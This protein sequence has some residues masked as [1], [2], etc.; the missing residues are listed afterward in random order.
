MC[1]NSSSTIGW[2][3][4]SD[5]GPPSGRVATTP[6][7]LVIDDDSIMRELVRH[8]LEDAGY[9]VAL[10]SGGAQGVDM[11]K[12]LGPALVI[13]DFAMPEV[14]GRDALRQIRAGPATASVP[15]LMLTAWSSVDDRKEVEALGA[16]WIEKPIARDA[17]LAVVRRMTGKPAVPAVVAKRAATDMARMEILVIDDDAFIRQLLVEV[18]SAEDRQVT[19]VPSGAEGLARLA[20]GPPALVLLDLGLP[21]ISGLKLLRL[22][23]SATGWEEVK[24]LMLTASSDLDNVIAAKQAGAIG[25][26]CKPIKAEVLVEMVEDVLVRDDL[27]WLDDYTRAW[28]PD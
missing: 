26:V 28:T 14:S 8:H 18:L 7:I 6:L 5:T 10:A 4:P 12:A 11:V 19:A 23:R 9:A 13:M 2:R 24:I 21:D 17:L 22:L 27:T 15:V 20:E 1:Q 25:Y 3:L 16:V